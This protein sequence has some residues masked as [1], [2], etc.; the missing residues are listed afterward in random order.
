M[1][2]ECE[3]GGKGE[4]GRRGAFSGKMGGEE[5]GRYAQTGGKEGDIWTD[6][7]AEDQLYWRWP[8]DGD[9]TEQ[10]G[11]GAGAGVGVG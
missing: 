1:R 8:P 9:R 10:V 5:K 4:R 2:G 6:F 3:D 11:M 7:S